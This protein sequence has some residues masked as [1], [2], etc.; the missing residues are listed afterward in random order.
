MAEEQGGSRQSRPWWRWVLPVVIVALVG[1]IGAYWYYGGREST[2]N[3]QIDG[4]ITPVASRVGGTVLR[5][6]VADNQRVESG[7][8]LVELD[9]A[10]RQIAVDRA[11][12]ELA[13]AEAAARA[14]EVGVPMSAT[15]TA[16]D[17]QTAG[18][19][20]DQARGG[21]AAA[22]GEVTAARGRVEA[23][24]GRLREKEAEATKTARDVERLKG[25]VE[26]DEISRQQFDT[27]TSAAEAARA[28]ADV[29]RSDIHAAT[30]AVGVAESRLRQSRA[31]LIQAQAGVGAARTAPQQVT[32]TRANAQAATA[33]VERARAA[34]AEAKLNLRYTT[35]KAPT[36]GIVSRRTVEPGQV[37]QQ[38]QPLMALVNLD[39]LWVTANFKETQLDSIRVGQPVS[40]S[41]DALGGQKFAG[42]VESIAGATGARFS[43]LPPENA[44]GNFVKVVQ[45]VPLKIALDKGQDPD[46]R[47]RPGMSVAPTVFVR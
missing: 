6:L 7:T 32:I 13:D 35:V 24:E 39:D 8:T 5:V 45:R 28:A 20:L 16:S 43:L 12:A 38:G 22:E 19:M 37:V 29:A 34:L 36:S 25:L 31:G 44:S 46:H 1:A 3:A 40:I 41:V 21:V 33:R 23:A 15:T 2:D 4:H 14:A 26:K 47:L 9:P 42:R 30:T 17:V 27:A 11:A 18:A 10:D